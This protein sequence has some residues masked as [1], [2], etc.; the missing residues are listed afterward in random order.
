MSELLL[1]GHNPAKSYLDSGADIVLDNGFRIEI[2]SVHCCRA[3]RGVYNIQFFSG[4]ARRTTRPTGFD[5]V[6][7]WCIDDDVFFVIPI[8][9]LPGSKFSLYPNSIK[10]RFSRFKEAW[11]LL[12]KETPS[13]GIDDR[14]EPAVKR[15]S[16]KQLQM[17]G[18]RELFDRLGMVHGDLVG[19]RDARPREGGTTL[20]EGRAEAT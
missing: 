20:V 13:I 11:H 17:S 12:A 8:D 18:H 15:R 6:I 3:Q 4:H 9:E 7:V 10:S 16:I 5:F 2:K 19:D 1:R 14:V